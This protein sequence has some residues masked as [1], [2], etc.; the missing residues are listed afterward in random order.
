MT[1]LSP[2]LFADDTTLHYSHSDLRSLCD[3]INNDLDHLK[4]WLNANYLTLNIRKS[5]YIIFS[6]RDVPPDLNISIQN[7][8]LEK[9]SEGKFLGIIIDERL[10]FK[11]HI[12]NLTKTI[13][14][15]TGVIC[16]LKSYIPPSIL[17]NLYYTFIYPHL[18]YG[19]LS[20]GSAFISL[21]E[22]IK[23]LQ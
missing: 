17:C 3:V 6:L 15:W 22:P 4:D 10:N 1:F 14:K 8:P 5:Y 20:W 7:V 16:K 23:I 13:S 11:S 21:L 12:N 9:K 2:V 18:N 19:I